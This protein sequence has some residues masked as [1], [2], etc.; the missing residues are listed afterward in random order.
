MSPRSG[1]RRERPPASRQTSPGTAA[2]SRLPASS[3]PSTS[4]N[5]T[6]ASPT[7]PRS[8]SGRSRRMSCGMLVRN[9]PP[10]TTSAC[11]ATALAICTTCLIERYAVVI[12]PMPITS[13]RSAFKIWARTASGARQAFASYTWTM[14]PSRAA[15][16]ASSAMP[17]GTWRGSSSSR[18]IGLTNSTLAIPSLEDPRGPGDRRGSRRRRQ[19]VGVQSRQFERAVEAV[20]DVHARRE[21]ER[22]AAI[23]QKLERRGVVAA[24]RVAHDPVL[25][26]P[27]VDPGE[28]AERLVDLGGLYRTRQRI[29]PH[30]RGAVPAHVHPHPCHAAELLGLHVELMG[31]GRLGHADVLFEQ[32]LRQLRAHG[33]GQR[34]LEHALDEDDVG[35]IEARGDRVLAPEHFARRCSVVAPVLLD[36]IEEAA[37]ELAGVVARGEDQLDLVRVE[38]TPPFDRRRRRIEPGAEPTGDEPRQHG[39]EVV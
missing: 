30:V 8:T 29:E 37:G 7:T 24:E 9:P 22:A 12:P 18:I 6:K 13:Q 11:G 35:P 3:R 33:F 31:Q 32:P 17:Y 34:T 14:W 26:R 39:R 25:R 19:V 4:G 1:V 16:A 27:A 23:L 28:E 36:E 10:A 21:P 5:V 38:Q 2:Q 20:R 15:I